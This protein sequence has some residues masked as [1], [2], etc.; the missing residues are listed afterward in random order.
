MTLPLTH[1]RIGQPAVCRLRLQVRSTSESCRIIRAATRSGEVVPRRHAIS[2][3]APNKGA[4][5]RLVRSLDFACRHIVAG[6]SAESARSWRRTG[7]SSPSVARRKMHRASSPGL[8][9]SLPLNLMVNQVSSNAA[10]RTASVFGSKDPLP[11]PR[12]SPLQG[13]DGPESIALKLLHDMA[14]IVERHADRS[15]T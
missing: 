2:L 15:A 10:S 1:V 3:V 12:M 14:E 13:R 5:L 9:L 11:S 8:T 4:S 7:S 6:A